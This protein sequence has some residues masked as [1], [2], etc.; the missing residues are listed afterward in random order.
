MSTARVGIGVLM[1]VVMIGAFVMSP[2]RDG[3]ASHESIAGD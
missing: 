2:S 3:L 1:T